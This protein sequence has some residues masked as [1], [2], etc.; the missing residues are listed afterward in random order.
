MNLNVEIHSLNT[1]LIKYGEGK[2]KLPSV[3]NRN[4]AS[5]V[6]QMFGGM[7]SLND[8]YICGLNGHNIQESEESSVN[9]KIREHLENIYEGC[10]DFAQKS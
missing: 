10:S 2:W 4:D 6:M 9:N 8:L 5:R 3:N 1:L 7:G